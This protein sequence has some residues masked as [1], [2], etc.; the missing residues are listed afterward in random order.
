MNHYFI[1]ND[2]PLTGERS[3]DFRF[4]GGAFK[5]QTNNGLFS[6]SHVDGASQLL[7]EHVPALSGSLLDMGC[8]YGPIGIVLARTYGLTLTMCDINE[9]ALKYAAVNAKHNNVS[10]DVIHSDGF[11]SVPGTY[12]AILLNPPI[13]AGKDSIFRMYAQSPAHLKPD[14]AFYIVIQKKHGAESHASA[15]NAIYEN[16]EVIYKKKGY[17]IFKCMNK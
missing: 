9:T 16:A 15:L 13:H 4:R 11:D 5:F 14:G 6:Y 10:A 1:S 17:F 3:I 8:G 2:A 7:M 12:D